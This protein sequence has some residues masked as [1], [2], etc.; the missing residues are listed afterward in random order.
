[1]ALVWT[2]LMGG[3]KKGGSEEAS[4]AEPLRA[5]FSVLPLNSAATAA[6]KEPEAEPAAP[7]PDDFQFP[8]SPKAAE[9]D[10][11]AQALAAGGGWTPS[12]VPAAAPSF[13][14]A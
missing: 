10:D 1:L 5:S 9:A 2:V 7:G 4:D 8:P 14:P 12:P 6:P 11:A 13:T 3:S